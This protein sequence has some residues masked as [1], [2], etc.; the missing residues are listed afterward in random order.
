MHAL[1]RTLEGVMP[2]DGRVPEPLRAGVEPPAPEEIAAWSSMPSGESELVA[3]GARPADDE[4]AAE[5]YLRTWSEPSVDVHGIAGGSPVLVKTV[6]PVEARA[7][8]SIRLVGGQD[9]AAIAETMMLLLREAAPAGAEVEITLH[10]S[11]PAGLVA[12]DAQAVQ[13]GL[14][15]FEHV[16]GTRPLLN[17]TG[18]AIPLVSALARRDVPTIL[19]GF[20]LNESNVHSPNERLVAHYL[21]LGVETT[22]ELYRR[23][24]ALG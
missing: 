9:P 17:R 21:P 18:G 24:G 22:C 19:T 16:L 12:A 4:A 5:F 1:A 23:L 7:N 6:I 11:S 3:A 15:A 20:A 14:D 2:R 8:V 13:I 10:S